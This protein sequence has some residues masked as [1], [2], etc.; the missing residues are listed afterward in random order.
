[1]SI[2]ID[3]Q[4]IQRYM[5]AARERAI[6]TGIKPVPDEAN[7]VWKENVRYALEAALNPPAVHR[8]IMEAGLAA[9]T[10]L[11]GMWRDMTAYQ[12]LTAAFPEMLAVWQKMQPDLRVKARVVFD[13]GI[14]HRRQDDEPGTPFR[15]HSRA[16]DMAPADGPRK[17]LSCDKCGAMT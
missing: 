17:R 9:I 12:V 10:R 1:M 7:E 8:D 14:A 13:E 2:K 6:V 3:D 4:V 5:R 11:N 15:Y 16:S